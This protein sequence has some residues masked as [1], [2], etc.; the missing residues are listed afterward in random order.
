MTDRKPDD[1]FDALH[2]RLATYGQEPPAQLWAGIRAQLPPPVAQPQLRRRRRWAPIGLVLALLS[3]IG[4]ASW[5]AW[6]SKTRPA[7][8]AS[9]KRLE[10]PS[11]SRAAGTNSPT[12]PSTAEPT[13]GPAATVAAGQASATP[14]SVVA[15]TP[16]QPRL[17]PQEQQ[18][19]VDEQAKNLA[20]TTNAPA[21]ATN[22]LA[23]FRKPSRGRNSTSMALAATTSR[24]AAKGRRSLALE[25][26]SKALA[27]DEHQVEEAHQLAAAESMRSREA[28]R[29]ER[30]AGGLIARNTARAG[31]PSRATAGSEAAVATT[32]V[33]SAPGTGSEPVGRP[34]VSAVASSEVNSSQPPSAMGSAAVPGGHNDRPEVAAFAG[35]RADYRAVAAAAPTGAAGTNASSRLQRNR[36]SAESS[37]VAKP[38]ELKIATGPAPAAPQPVATAP[39]T[40]FVAARWAVQLLAGA[41][42]TYRHT[43]FADSYTPTSSPA[44]QPTRPSSLGYHNTSPSVVELERPALGG[45]AQVSLSRALSDNWTLSAGL[46]YAEYGTRLSLQ[47]VT[48]PAPVA[49]NSVPGRRDTSKVSINRRDTYR[50]VTVPMRLGYTKSLTPRW[51]AGLLAGAD[52]AFYVGGRSTEGSACACQTQNWGAG[53]SPYR[54]VSVGMSAGVEVRYRLTERLE[55]LAQ[56]TATYFLTPLAKPQSVYSTR[57]LFSS[58]ALLGASFDLR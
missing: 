15:T 29:R 13:G 52:V 5:Y 58:G 19:S 41:A 37:L 42:Y 34:S 2:E 20:A 3:F 56:P 44:P 57:Y 38:V 31:R 54:R 28:S 6:P 9:S 50:F 26:R 45:G 35:A 12:S 48:L 21:P 4:I 22:T 23:E 40:P 43:G 8:V 47:L 49:I 25:N 27:A 1:L 24:A 33:A 36:R 51:R 17:A 11:R 18:A 14:G 53:N 39:P 55:L 32:P 30:R 7:T 46:G 16:P 10:A